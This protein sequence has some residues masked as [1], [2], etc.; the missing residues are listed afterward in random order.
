MPQARRP[1]HNAPAVSN[2]EQIVAD[3]PAN[4]SV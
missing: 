2:I 4:F 1:E 3:L